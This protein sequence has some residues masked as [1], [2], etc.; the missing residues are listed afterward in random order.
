MD[1]LRL[2]LLAGL[3]AHKAV[4]EV[5]KRRSPAPP[6]PAATTLKTRIVKTAK[7]GILLGIVGQTLLPDV[8]PL[9]ADATP[10]RAVG[11]LLFTVGLAMALAGRLQLGDNWSDI[12]SA[13]VRREHRVVSRG[14]YR[15]IRHPIY[16]GDL[17]LLAGFELALNSWLV[18]GPLLLAPVVARQAAKEEDA[19]AET[20]PGY[21]QY[22]LRTNRFLP[23]PRLR[24]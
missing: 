20:L 4:W 5:L 13:V 14:I 22:R 19:L 17:I 7:V 2:Y 8:L 6:A 10:L 12:E 21:D 15:Y 24:R 16:S 1:P 11:T 9:A 3:L 23:V 18:V